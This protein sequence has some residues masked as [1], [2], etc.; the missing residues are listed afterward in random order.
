MR[1]DGKEGLFQVMSED[2]NPW[3]ALQRYGITPETLTGE[4]RK[5]LMLEP[6]RVL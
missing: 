5:E 4:L 3:P 6:Y 1:R 2:V